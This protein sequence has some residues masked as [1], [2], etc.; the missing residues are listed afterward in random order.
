LRNFSKRLAASG[1]SPLGWALRIFLLRLAP[2]RWSAR[3]RD[4][5]VASALRAARRYA[6]VYRLL[7]LSAAA[8]YG[9]KLPDREFLLRRLTRISV[10]LFI[11]VAL[12]YR[13]RWLRDK[14]ADSSAA[15]RALRY[16]LDRSKERVRKN[17][18]LAASPGEK[19]M[20]EA[21]DALY[22]AG[23]AGETS[24]GAEAVAGGIAEGVAGNGAGKV[25][26]KVTGKV[27]GGIA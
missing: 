5:L 17:D 10:E 22:A 19:I 18:R 27:A 9:R 15:R 25:T 3:D 20:N 13:I 8:R 16:F 24:G 1:R 26:A 23:A 4:P 7:F 21:V 2:A 11:L 14:G 12:A 6:R